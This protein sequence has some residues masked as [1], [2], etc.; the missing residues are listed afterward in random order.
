MPAELL[1]K[2]VLAIGGV[3]V[4]GAVVV[5]VTL[6]GEQESETIAGGGEASTREVAAAPAFSAD[7]LAEA[8]TDGWITNGGTISNQRYS[9]LDQ[10]DTG[11]VGDL[12]GMWMT[13]LK[14]GTAAKYS[15]AESRMR[16]AM[17]TGRF[18]TCAW[19]SIAMRAP[20]SSSA[21]GRSVQG[22]SRTRTSPPPRG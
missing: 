21:I 1:E 2:V 8:P 20:G 7:Q 10:I 4:V 5:L 6:A 9:P 22:A 16:V 12:K 13:D 17:C 3:L 18:A 14:S 19:P 15:S 11:N